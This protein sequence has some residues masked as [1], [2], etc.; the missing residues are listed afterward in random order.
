MLLS[1]V[2]KCLSRISL[3]C[4]FHVNLSTVSQTRQA[5]SK[6]TTSSGEQQFAGSCAMS[7][8]GISFTASRSH[9]A[10]DSGNKLGGET[11]SSLPGASVF[12]SGT[13]ST[14]AG[15]F[16]TRVSRSS[17]NIP[18]IS[19][20]LKGKTVL[21]HRKP[22]LPPTDDDGQSDDDMWESVASDASVPVNWKATAVQSEAVRGCAMLRVVAWV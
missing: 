20:E 3:A 5:L 9:S 19:N 15:Y 1:F 21:V 8:G 12:S 2:F 7:S 16:N 14:F 13:I 10:C 11:D 6:L 18:A 4:Q 17:A 22:T